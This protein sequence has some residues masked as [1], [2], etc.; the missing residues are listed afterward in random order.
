M[1]IGI[2]IPAYNA[3]PWIADAIGSV[4]GQ[5]HGAWSLI[6]VDDG[7]EDATDAAARPFLSDPRVAL[8]RQ[9]RAG[10]SA[11]RNR[12]MAA[13]G[14]ADALLF[15]DA[16]DWLAPDALT[17]LV[18]ALDATPYAAASSGPA[19]FVAAHA[20]PGARAAR[21]LPGRQGE[22]L[23]W[24][25]ERNLFAN[26]GH[27]LIRAEA[28]REAGGFRTDLVYGEDWE[29]LVRVA[30]LGRFACVVGPA[31]V[32]SI[33]RRLEGAYLRQATEAAAFAG[34]MAAIFENEMLRA[35]IGA[36]RLDTIRAAAEAENHWIMGGALLT[37]G[38]HAEGRAALCRSLAAKPSLK[39][40]ALAAIMHVLHPLPRE[41]AGMPTHGLVPGVGG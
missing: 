28:A 22:I 1:R 40:K 19:G 29:F 6:V 2:I 23:P 9:D 17:R 39:R 24:L 8:I 38:R 21:V 26:C 12:G 41:R 25:L 11:A 5:T 34:C 14:E 7:S 15:L 3:A 31:P 20:R 4:I 27:V 36:A 33:R 32:A 16:D 35:R 37:Q 30:A 10:V 18:R 13:C